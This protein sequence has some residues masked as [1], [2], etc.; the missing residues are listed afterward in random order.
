MAVSISR[1]QVRKIDRLSTERYGIPS[2]I[3]MEN[4]GRNAAQVIEGIYGPLGR[5]A[6]VCGPGNNGGDGCVIARHL[7]NFGWQVRLLMTGDETAMTQDTRTNYAIVS[8]M[9]IATTQSS[10]RS[11][12]MEWITGIEN[13]EVLIDA[14]LG[15]GFRGPVRSPVADYITSINAAA[16]RA[17]VAVDVPSGLDCDSGQP[18]HATVR[19]DWTI[20]FVA[21][22]PGMYT[23]E[24][25]EYVGRFTT[26]DIGAPRELIAE[27]ASNWAIQDSNL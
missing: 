8:A 4:A 22:K 10:D 13:D 14:L 18:S 11:L 7:H 3:L 26:A 2:L 9:A 1:E 5:A 24:A 23:V 16:R 12:A 27:V 21:M 6:V 20:T 17:V 25:A 15:T 19:A